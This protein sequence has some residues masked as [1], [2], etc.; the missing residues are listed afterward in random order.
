MLCLSKSKTPTQFAEELKLS[1]PNVSRALREL[2]KERT[3]I[4]SVTQ[5]N[6]KWMSIKY[7]YV[8]NI[9]KIS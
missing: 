2:E 1:I 8:N 6:F 5:K 3:F 9:L 7:I 4:R